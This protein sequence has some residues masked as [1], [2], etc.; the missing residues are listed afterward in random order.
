[1]GCLTAQDDVAKLR[2][3]LAGSNTIPVE[4]RRLPGDK[5]KKAKLQRKKFSNHKIGWILQFDG[6]EEGDDQ[7]VLCLD[8]GEDKENS[9]MSLFEGNM[10]KLIP[11]EV[12][13]IFF[14]FIYFCSPLI[15]ITC[16]Q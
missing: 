13:L 7:N 16:M 6:D 3:L 4:A 2:E 1:M 11:D 12:C 9:L 10:L 15:F 8:G 14:Q 5:L